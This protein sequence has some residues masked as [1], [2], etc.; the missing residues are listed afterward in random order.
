M[1]PDFQW[2]GKRHVR[3]RGLLGQ[4]RRTSRTTGRVVLTMLDALACRGPDSAGIALI[5]P[6]PAAGARGCLVGP[7]HS[8]RRR[9]RPAGGDRRARLPLPRGLSREPPGEHP[10][11]C[12][13]ARRRGSRPSTWNE[14]SAPAGGAWRFSVSDSGSTWS[15]RSARPHS[16][17][18][19]M[20]CRPGEAP[21]P[22]ATR[23]CRPRAGSTCPT[24]SPS[25]PTECP[26][27]RP[28]TTA[29]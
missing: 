16:S 15:S 23:E 11:V 2:L 25:G 5:G 24:R 17:R 14:H 7:N 8:G 28:F 19:P 12:L 18:R 26:T 22:S 3:D 10:A 21:W 6:P 13:P 1:P 29:T 4:E 20:A 9:A 27:S